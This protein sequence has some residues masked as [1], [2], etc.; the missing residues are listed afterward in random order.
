MSET[1]LLCRP[2]T[3]AKSAREIGWRVRIWLKIRFRLIW[4]GILFDALTLLVNEKRGAGDLVR[5]P[6]LSG[7]AGN[8]S[9]VSYAAETAPDQR[10][11]NPIEL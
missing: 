7:M 4:R 2:E 1:V 8:L 11:S 5:L 10:G 9:S 6:D 3:R